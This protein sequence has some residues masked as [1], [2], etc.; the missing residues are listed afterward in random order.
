MLR[1]RDGHVVLVDGNV[2]PIVDE[3]APRARLGGHVPQRHRGQAPHRRTPAPGAPR[4]ADGPAQPPRV[5]IAPAPRRACRRRN[6]TRATRCCTSTW[7]I[8]NRSTTPPA[9]PRATNCCANWPSCCA[10][11]ARRRC[12]RA[13]GRRRVRDPAGRR[14]DRTGQLRRRKSAARDRHVSVR[15]AGRDVPHRREHRATRIRRRKVERLRTA[16]SRRR[17]VLPRQVA[18]PR[19]RRRVLARTRSRAAAAVAERRGRAAQQPLSASAARV[20]PRTPEGR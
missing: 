3:H 17:D 7:I 11:V 13:A 10:A 20:P 9:T 1:R 15:V 2:S 16:L 6:R 12:A 5:R 19:S 4:P 14:D 8:S 18:R